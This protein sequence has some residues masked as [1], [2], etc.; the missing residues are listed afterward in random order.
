MLQDYSIPNQTITGTADMNP[1][2][3]KRRVS[4]SDSPG[5]IVDDVQDNQIP[6]A[7]G[8]VVLSQTNHTGIDPSSADEGRRALQ[9]RLLSTE[10]TEPDQQVDPSA[11]SYGDKQPHRGHLNPLDSPQW[12]PIP[13]GL[14]TISSMPHENLSGTESPGCLNVDF[15]TN[16]GMSQPQASQLPDAH[17]P[18]LLRFQG[19][20]ITIPAEQQIPSRSTMPS[21]Q[22]GQPSLHQGVQPNLDIDDGMAAN[23]V[24]NSPLLKYP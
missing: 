13:P 11:L 19:T 17:N 18:P 22:F 12:V 1:M 4:T 23:F 3:W 6:L 8:A 24:V 2:S 7:H 14:P 10:F 15:G 20:Y 5:D 9:R 16:P 21:P